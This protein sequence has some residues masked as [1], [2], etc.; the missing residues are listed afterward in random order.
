M[1]QQDFYSVLG[2]SKNSSD[3]EIKS[4]YRKQALKWHP[5]KHTG[6]AKKEAEEK[7]KEINRAYEVLRDPQKKQM[8]DQMGHDAF[9]RN[10]TAG[11]GGFGAG[12][13]FSGGFQQGPFRYSYSTS[14]NVNFEDLFGGSDPFDIFEQFF[15][16]SYGA[17]RPRKPVYQATIDFMEA[18]RGTEKSFVIQGK[19]RKVKI[20]AGVDNN[21]R[22][23]F[24]DFDL[25]VQVKP[26]E[27]FKRQGQDIVVDQKLSFTQAAL[28]DTI[29]VPTIDGTFKLKIR[30]GTQPGTLVR[31]HGK[32]VAYPQSSRRGDQYVRFIIEVPKSLSRKQKE[33][34][35]EFEES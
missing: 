8:Y 4:A 7:F 9:N 28:G 21:M 18:I 33:L 15:G 11:P 29:D 23:R 6:E 14:G 13:P 32:G 12:D 5:D 3:A 17:Q 16:G 27:K 26:H 25:V 10:G 22:I 1:A 24:N 31:L 2:V 35:K 19:Q 34:L 20:P 30:P